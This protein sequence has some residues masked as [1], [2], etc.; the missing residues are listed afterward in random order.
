MVP[1]IAVEVDI[2]VHDG[3]D[4]ATSRNPAI[5]MGR[6]VWWPDSGGGDGERVASRAED[7]EEDDDEDGAHDKFGRAR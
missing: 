6:G 2:G 4:G 5:D 7:E 1:P 3:T